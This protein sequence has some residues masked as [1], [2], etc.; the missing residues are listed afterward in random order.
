MSDEDVINYFK[1]KGISISGEADGVHGILV[2]NKRKGKNGSMK[3]IDN[4]IYSIGFHDGIIPSKTWLQ[5]QKLCEDN[6]DKSPSLATSHEAL[7]T[8]LLKC[9]K[10]GAN[11]RVAYGQLDK[12]KNKKRFYY[13][14]TMKHNSGG[15]RCNNR[16]IKGLELDDLVLNIIKE[17]SIDKLTI[18]H[19]LEYYRTQ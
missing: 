7:L 9:A 10:C 5:A 17:L 14:C 19:E 4:W 12:T 11:M 16:N 15:T 1:D 13:M 18:I 3:T 2:F 6:K 8:G